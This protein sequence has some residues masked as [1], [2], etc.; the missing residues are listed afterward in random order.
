MVR[1]ARPE[2]VARIYELILELAV[3]ERLRDRAVGNAELLHEH[4]FGEAKSVEALV[5]EDEGEIVGYALFFTTYS[6]FLTRPG[7][8]LEDV[9]VLPQA[10]GKGLGKALLREVAR[11]AAERGMERLDWIVLHW[12]QPSIEFYRSLGAEPLSEWQVYRLEGEAL[13]AFAS[14]TGIQP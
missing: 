1:P 8:W 4:L 2:D 9:F 10:R 3:Y 5:A 7:L 14:G 11:T 12:N 6:S 13:S